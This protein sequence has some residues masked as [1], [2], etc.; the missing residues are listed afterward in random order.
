MIVRQYIN[1]RN[2][3]LLRLFTIVR[4]L[5][6]YWRYLFQT[7]AFG[8]LFMLLQIPGPYF[9]KILIDEVYPHKDFSLLT[10]VLLLTTFMSLG[11]GAL[12]FVAGYFGQW[13]GISIGYDFQ[14]R[15]YRHIQSLDFSFFDNRET[16][17]ILSRFR[18][19][20]TALSGVIDLINTL[21]LNSLQLL[22]F[23]PVLFFIN[24]KLAL[25]SLAILPFDTLLVMV[26]KIYIRKYTTEIAEQGAEL[27]AKNYE[28][29]SS[30][31]TV[32]ALG[33]EASFFDKVHSLLLRLAN[34]RMRLMVFEGASGYIGTCF[35]AMGT[36]AYGYYGWHEVLSGNLTLGSYMAFT[37][38]VGYLYGPV[39]NLIGL[40]SEA[41]E[42]MVHTNR[43][44]EI[45]SIEP[46][47]REEKDKSELSQFKSKIEFQAVEF[48]YI[49]DRPVL[50]GINM[51]ILA[52]QTTAIVGKSGSG[53]STLAKLIPRFYDPS[54]GNVLID[55]VDIRQFR[56]NSL[57]EII[58]FVLQGSVLFQGSILDN[59]TFGKSISIMEIETA[60][61]AA[62]IHD[63]VTQL[64]EGYNTIIGEQGAQLSEGQ[65]QRIALARVLLQDTPILILD[66]P[67]AALDNE[68]EHYVQEAMKE[69]CKERT[70]II[71]AHRL[72]TIRRAD[73]IVVLDE[74]RIV[75]EGDHDSLMVQNG[76]YALLQEH[77]ARI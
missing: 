44:F 40:I 12:Q 9:T 55:E 45:Y 10:F 51:E 16:G 68:S 35:T 6:P 13:V 64:P 28:S 53:K 33:L 30:I 65:R 20:R 37:A 67:T 38:Y 39:T 46:A 50:R 66:E 63:F 11:V 23:P 43:F 8:I 49:S 5:R 47:I 1:Y 14:T 76:V 61:R 70:V 75:E 32:Q 69:I 4:M 72:S 59:L 21:I 62:Y 22:I 19:M 27:S 48:S 3:D 18:D 29:I 57:R 52:N 7:M 42:T 77:S 34:T 60:T 26:S 41:E 58:G 74:G 24:W 73:K 31:R 17:E 54:R 2:V 36:L 56:L 15:F 71:I 25:I